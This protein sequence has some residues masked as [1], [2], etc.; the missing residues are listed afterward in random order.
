MGCVKETIHRMI[1]ESQKVPGSPLNILKRTLVEGELNVDDALAYIKGVYT[2]AISKNDQVTVRESLMALLHVL[3]ATGR[4]KEMEEY[5]REAESWFV[6]DDTC[7]YIFRY[8]EG[9]Y[10]LFTLD[11]ERFRRALK[12]LGRCAPF[13]MLYL[14]SKYRGRYLPMPH[15]LHV[16]PIIY[17][18]IVGVPCV[19][20]PPKVDAEKQRSLRSILKILHASVML[21]NAGAYESFSV[22]RSNL[23]DVFT[24]NYIRLLSPYLPIKV[25]RDEILIVINLFMEKAKATGNM[26]DYYS[27]LLLHA[28]ISGEDVKIPREHYEFVKMLTPYAYML[29]VKWRS[30]E[31]SFAELYERLFRS[32]KLGLFD[33]IF[34]LEKFVL[35]KAYVNFSD[36]LNVYVGADRVS[37][38]NT[39]LKTKSSLVGL[40]Y[41]LALQSGERKWGRLRNFLLEHADELYPDIYRKLRNDPERLR[42]RIKKAVEQDISRISKV[43]TTGRINDYIPMDLRFYEVEGPKGKITISNSHNFFISSRYGLTL[44]LENSR[45]ADVF[46]AK[47]HRLRRDFLNYFTDNVAHTTEIP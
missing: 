27:Y 40:S 24:S 37:L 22:V 1:V 6:G 8:Y 16:E 20:L 2:E 19:S 30:G 25:S 26:L 32:G 7:R 34:H 41:L 3:M 47:A 9:L 29:A 10:S 12:E 38:R 36:R 21:L 23:K 44:V 4:W 46:K 13:E 35:N 18:R 5:L 14:F 33:H 31:V 28:F 45:W 11:E 39:Y 15:H 43:F 42:Q 17:Q